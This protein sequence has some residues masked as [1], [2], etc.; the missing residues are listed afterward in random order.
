MIRSS[1]S[2]KVPRAQVRQLH[3]ADDGPDIH[4][5]SAGRLGRCPLGVDV[6]RNPAI[7]GIAYSLGS[8]PRLA[9]GLRVCP[10]IH[11]YPVCLC[12]LAGRG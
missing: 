11:R 3:L 7:E 10:V 5:D 8:S 1:T 9:Q 6:H 4:V 12:C 2:T